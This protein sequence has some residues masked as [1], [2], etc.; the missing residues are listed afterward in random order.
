MKNGSDLQQNLNQLLPPEPV[1]LSTIFLLQD[2]ENIFE[3]QPAE[4]L[5]VLKNVFGL[6]GID[7]AKEQVNEER[8]QTE[9]KIKYLQDQSLQN[10][11]LNKRLAEAYEL[12]T[13]IHL[14]QKNTF[15]EDLHPLIKQLSLQDFSLNG[16]ELQLYKE[17]FQ[18][19]QSQEKELIADKAKQEQ[20]QKQISEK[21][22]IIKEYQEKE[23]KLNEE[24]AHLEQRIASIDVQKIETIKQEKLA[25]Y[26]QINTLDTMTT[27]LLFE[28]LKAEDLEEVIVMIQKLKDKGKEL[29]NLA[30]IQQLKQEELAKAKE[31]L[32]NFDLGIQ[33]EAQFFCEAIN[34]YCK[35][36][37][38]IN[39]QHFE[40][41]EQQRQSME[42]EIKK[43]ES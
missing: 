32:A 20:L 7:E 29:A 9:N 34:D 40:Q 16:L 8:K 11:K 37:K 14:P 36:I 19:L 26:E 30:Q 24:I 43:L 13:H 22:H 35:C 31:R 10:S 28:D 27:P 6:L 41:L 17:Y 42:A 33:T 18:Q 15:F 4:R 1:F 23:K 38:S 5:I 25:L 3:M 21:S 12:N 2:A 39:K